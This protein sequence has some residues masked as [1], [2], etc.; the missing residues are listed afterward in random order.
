MNG[1]HRI[2]EFRGTTEEYIS[3][4]ER[5]V[6][7]CRQQQL[8]VQPKPQR[9]KLELDSFLS[10]IP[11]SSQWRERRE[12]M[13]L[14]SVDNHTAA[15][16]LLLESTSLPSDETAGNL[17]EQA[18]LYARRT[19]A[20]W[21]SGNFATC[22]AHFRKIVFISWCVVLVHNGYSKD[23]VDPIMQECVSKTKKKN[24]HRLRTGITWVN[25]SI[26]VLSETEW[27]HRSTEIFVICMSLISVP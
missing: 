17:V 24:L 7:H 4:L 27:G 18:K 5:E 13:Q 19:N 15:L 2:D 9:W 22:V 12:E 3:Y 11:V 16:K 25:R 26:A 10:K 23:V 20:F 14:V 8:L 21:Q 1:I 6:F